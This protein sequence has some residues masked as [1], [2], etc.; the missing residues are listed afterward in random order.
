MKKQ[1]PLIIVLMF[2]ANSIYAQEQNS[3]Q[4]RHHTITASPLTLLGDGFLITYEHSLPYRASVEME[5]GAQGLHWSKYR[6]HINT[7]TRPGIVATMGYKYFFPLGSRNKAMA[8]AGG[9]P[10][11]SFFFKTRLTFVH[12]W[13]SYNVFVG[14]DGQNI[15]TQR[16]T[17]HENGLSIALI[18][19]YQFIT[20][21]G[22]VLAPFFGYSIPLAIDGPFH[23]LSMPG[24]SAAYFGHT[25][26]GIKLGCAL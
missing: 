23:T 19:G 6:G 17:F 14:N 12:Q 15:I 20:R 2:L 1:L 5:M 18:A 16:L 22:F 3:I 25:T 4:L 8:V 11:H 13:S 7:A 26:F 21:H 24:N 10:N 9:L